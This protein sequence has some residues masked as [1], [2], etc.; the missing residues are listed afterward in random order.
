M[1]V[2]NG[3]E[4]LALPGPTNVPDRVLQAMHRPAVDLYEGDMLETTR[5]LLADLKTIFKTQGEAYI[6]AANGHGAWEAALSNTL[7]PGDKVLVLESGRFARSWAEH[8]TLSRVEV[9]T[10]ETD[11]HS[12]VDPAALEARLK[13]DS[14]HEI[15][16]VLVV[17][18]DTASS[19]CNDIPALR[20]AI[21]AAGHP[22]L[23]MVD[24]IASLACVPYEMDAWGV[25]VT[26]AGSQKGLMTP[27]GLSFIAANDKARAIKDKAKLRARYWDW[28]F[29]DG[30]EHYMKYCGTPPEH[31]LFG[32]REAID[33]LREEGLEAV[34]ER[35]RLL[36]GATRA[37]IEAWGA[38]GAISFN[39]HDPAARS[40]SVT[41]VR[42]AGG[43]SSELRAYCRDKAGVVLGLG[44]G[45]L[46][47]EAFRIAHMGHCNA[48]MVMATLGV[49]EMG[50]HAL[51]APLGKQSGVAAAAR[52]LGER[53]KA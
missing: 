26:V 5:S 44:I 32:L 30:G 9:E 25:D 27:P 29:R 10:I 41:T 16:A 34:F 42:L 33:M 13:A 31:L 47:S 28:E 3:R 51:G 20:K 1:T 48:N 36:A 22:A 37:A 52:Y 19:V 49:V 23:F 4:L 8:A 39:I 2:R 40:D 43:K 14:A 6:Y 11:W 21:D 7:S 38:G 12:A 15:K 46:E 53:V 24:T 45:G 50:L 18:I 35:H 17:Q